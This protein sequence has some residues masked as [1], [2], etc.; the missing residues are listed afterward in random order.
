MSARVARSPWSKSRSSAIWRTT[1]EHTATAAAGATASRPSVGIRI[2][3]G[4]SPRPRLTAARISAARPWAR[5]RPSTPAGSAELVA[6]AG[7]ALGDGEQAEVRQDHPS[8]AVRLRGGALAPRRHLLGD[9]AAPARH[10][11]DVAQLPPGLLGD[12]GRR[13]VAEH[14][15]ALVEGPFEAAQ[16]PEPVGQH[17]PQLQ[18][19]GHVVHGVGDLAL[20]DRTL[21][22]VREPVGLGQGDA[23]ASG[24][25]AGRAKGRTSRGSRRRSGCRTRWR[26]RC[27]RRPSA[28]RGPARPHGP[29]PC[30][31]PRRPR[32]GGRGRRPAGRRVPPCPPRRSE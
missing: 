15:V 1:P 30:P 4:G 16:G 20:R 10:A 25:P 31:V 18:Q 9:A 19:V 27:R 11:A 7:R 12:A 5:C 28:H 26:G 21:Q 22:P 6:V 2:W 14:L 8:G 17:D 24:R 3:S 23:P 32:P 13:A 29:P